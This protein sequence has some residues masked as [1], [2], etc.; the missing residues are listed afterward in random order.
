MTR[1]RAN[2]LVVLG[3]PMF[4]TERERIAAGNRKP[5]YGNVL[6]EAICPSRGPHGLWREP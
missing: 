6:N 1:E 2:A 3:T 5:T 4:F